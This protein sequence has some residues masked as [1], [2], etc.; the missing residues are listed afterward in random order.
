MKLPGFGRKKAKGQAAAEGGEK[1]E[2]AVAALST[3][4]PQGATGTPFDRFKTSPSLVFVG[5]SK[6]G[7]GKSFI[8]LN[9]VIATAAAGRQVYAVDLDLDNHTLTYRLPERNELENLAE[10]MEEHKYEMM[11]VVQV[12]KE[13][14]VRAKKSGY[15]VG[16]PVLRG[17]S[18]L[19]CNNNPVTFDVRLIPAY[20]IMDMRNQ[21]LYDV[22]ELNYTTYKMGTDALIKYLFERFEEMK[23]KSEKPPLVFFDGKQKSNLGINY[24]PLYRSLLQYVDTFLFVTEPGY[25][26]F[27]EIRTAYGDYSDKMVIVVSKVLPE[28]WSEVTNFMRDA[29]S[30]KIPVFVIPSD[31]N[32]AKI[33]EQNATP[34]AA[35]GLG[36]R[37]VLFTMALA[38]LMKMIDDEALERLGCKEKV[39]D[40]VARYQRLYEKLGLES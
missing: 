35:K 39:M 14:A 40:V 13:G 8:T 36:R 2:G 9:L 4:V 28:Q 33:Y 10:D 25:L 1:A 23:K 29:A 3:P 26:D 12:L 18:T 30:S 24:E 16:V 37:T 7:V 19:G 27:G 20:N 32:D 38:Y 21:M 5:S 15:R 31:D 34:P 6:G 22:K 17:H 11:N